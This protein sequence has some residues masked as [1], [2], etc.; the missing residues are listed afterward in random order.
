[1]TLETTGHIIRG[2]AR[3]KNPHLNKQRLIDAGLN[4]I[5]EQGYN[6]TGIKQIVDSVNLPKGSFYNYF[7]SKEA[8][9]AEVIRSY[10]QQ[11]KVL[12]VT[13][14]NDENSDG[15]YLLQ[16]LF[17]KLIKI[18]YDKE[19]R[20][21]CLVGNLAAELADTNETIRAEL[22]AVFADWEATT[23]ELIERGQ[24]Q[25][26]IR[27]DVSADQLATFLWTSFEGALLR[28]KVEKNAV[29]LEQWYDFTLVDF[30]AV[31]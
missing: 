30:V 3:I 9:G 18:F 29:P 6:N 8:F 2:M 17:K 7:D 31:I 27:Q 16:D 22:S 20:G 11:I 15:L 1:M 24:A 14:T 5:I 25:K 21:G 10:A 13:A 26:T 4:I 19:F 12:I 23:K 28:M